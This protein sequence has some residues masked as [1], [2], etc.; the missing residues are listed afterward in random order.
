[1]YDT[2]FD[3]EAAELSAIDRG[4]LWF[5]RILAIGVAIRA[6]RRTPSFPASPCC[7]THGQRQG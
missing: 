5:V 2:S 3:R 7:R 4:A 6:T 1:M